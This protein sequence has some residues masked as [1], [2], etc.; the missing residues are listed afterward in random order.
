MHLCKKLVL[1][2]LCPV[3]R[4]VNPL[5]VITHGQ[6]RK[7]V[8]PLQ[9]ITQLE[10]FEDLRT[11]TSRIASFLKLSA[12]VPETLVAITPQRDTAQP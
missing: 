11:P 3:G 2:H 12:A 7:P 1:D 4:E 8:L 9:E 5:G 6:R 10:G